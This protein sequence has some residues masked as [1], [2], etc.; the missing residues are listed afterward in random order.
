[1]A[2]PSLPLLHVVSTSA[3]PSPSKPSHRD[4]AFPQKHPRPYWFLDVQLGLC[5]LAGNHRIQHFIG[6]FVVATVQVT[7]VDMTMSQA[8][9]MSCSRS[10][11]TSS[12]E[13][14]TIS[15]LCIY[16]TGMLR[17]RMFWCW[18]IAG[19][20]SFHPWLLASRGGTWRVDSLQSDVKQPRHLFQAT[21]QARHCH[22]NLSLG[23]FFGRRSPCATQALYPGRTIWVS[24][25][26]LLPDTCATKRRM[27]TFKTPSIDKNMDTG[28][29]DSRRMT[30]KDT[31]D[32]FAYDT[33]LRTG[34]HLPA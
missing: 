27:R 9:S 16:R 17:S 8:T 23:S 7:G 24:L 1:M 5:A 32:D 12:G 14:E 30:L 28:V 21:F 20:D 29:A 26:L 13:A 6:G 31:A 25:G 33:N 4:N 15:A 18:R 11:S 2:S 22:L 34:K 19:S 10:S 3:F